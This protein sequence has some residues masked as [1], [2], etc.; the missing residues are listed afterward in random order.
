MSFLGGKF[1]GPPILVGPWGGRTWNSITSF[2]WSLAKAS[3]SVEWWENFPKMFGKWIWKQV[4]M[5]KNPCSD[6]S[7]K[8]YLKKKTTHGVETCLEASERRKYCKNYVIK[9]EVSSAPTGHSGVRTCRLLKSCQL[10]TAK[11]HAY[12]ACESSS[13]TAISTG[14]H[15][16]V[17]FGSHWRHLQ[18]FQDLFEKGQGALNLQGK[19]QVH[20]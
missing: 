6:V 17:L 15:F 9:V 19:I 5:S 16:H 10:H 13:A 8:K 3:V 14:M 4:N 12:I 2:N 18:L 1:L 7:K 11:Q 20:K